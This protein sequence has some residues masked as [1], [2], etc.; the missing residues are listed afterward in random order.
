M[1][2]GQSEKHKERIDNKE[3]DRQEKESERENELQLLSFD[4]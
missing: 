3:T 4:I 2:E 1:R